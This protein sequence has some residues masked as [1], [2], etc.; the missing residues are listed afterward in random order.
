MNTESALETARTRL[1]P[2]L[3]EAN[4]PEPNRL[5]VVLKDSDLAAAAR[6]LS[7]WGYLSAMTGLDLGME[8][9]TMEVL[10]H[11]CEGAAVVTLRVHLL[12]ESPSVPTLSEVIPSASF[13]ER[14]LHEMFGVTVEGLSDSSYLFL[15]DDWTEGV[16]PL[17]KD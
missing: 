7:D 13:Y 11:F 15:P 17:R 9:N 8:A 16:Y 10:Y 5:D 3:I 14:E 2:W 12:R 6:A 4:K 1:D